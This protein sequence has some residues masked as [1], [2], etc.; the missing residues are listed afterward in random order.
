MPIY[1]PVPASSEEPLASILR[2]LRL[3]VR[4]PGSYV[5]TNLSQFNGR[6]YGGQVFGQAV[7]AAWASV[8]DSYPDRDIHSITAAFMRPGD[9]EETNFVRRGRSERFTFVFDAACTRL[10]VRED[11]SSLPR[12]I[13]RAAAWG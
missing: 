13:P 6:V 2:T 11:H 8:M 4:E 7:M 3:E 9:Q 5:G 12:V 10:P 1:L